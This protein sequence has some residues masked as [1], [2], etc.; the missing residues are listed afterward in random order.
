M[1]LNLIEQPKEVTYLDIADWL[2][3]Q[4][5]NSGAFLT[6]EIAR[7]HMDQFPFAAVYQD[8]PENIDNAIGHMKKRVKSLGSDYP[9]EVEAGTLFCNQLVDRHMPYALLLAISQLDIRRSSNQLNTVAKLFEDACEALLSKP[10]DGGDNYSV[11]NFGWPSATG[12]P[13]QFSD[14]ISWAAQKLNLPVGQGYKPAKMKDGGVD[15]IRWRTFRDGTTHQHCLFQCTVGPDFLEKSRQIDIERWRSWIQFHA[16]PSRAVSMPYQAKRR[17][18]EYRA[19]EEL[20]GIV[21]DRLRLVEE[22]AP[23]TPK[24]TDLARATLKSIGVL[25]DPEF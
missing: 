12:R 11:L 19:T 13:K 24:A 2:E 20:G 1:P 7:T 3:I 6:A 21:Y 8:N 5:L 15:L 10:V 18:P 23:T 4:F 17:S 14:A 25:E 9:F 22:A 16:E